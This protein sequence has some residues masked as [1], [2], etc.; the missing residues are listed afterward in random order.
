VTGK[1]RANA[2][3]VAGQFPTECLPDFDRFHEAMQQYDRIP[4]TLG[5]V[6]ESCVFVYKRLDIHDVKGV[7]VVSK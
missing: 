4:F 1:V 6:P 3:E 5:T 2:K 7:D